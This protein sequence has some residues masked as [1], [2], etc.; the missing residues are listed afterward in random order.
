VLAFPFIFR[1][2]LDSYASKISDGMKMA[3]SKAIASLAHE[4]SPGYI[5]EI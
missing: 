2:A 3:A 1:G 5:N 4:E